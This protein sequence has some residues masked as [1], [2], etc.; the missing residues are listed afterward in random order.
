MFG[1]FRGLT[2]IRFVGYPIPSLLIRVTLCDGDGIRCTLV[3]TGYGGGKWVKEIHT[4]L[5]GVPNKPKTEY[6]KNKRNTSF[7]LMTM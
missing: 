4:F 1:H 3:L 6:T 2:E 7:I 5:A